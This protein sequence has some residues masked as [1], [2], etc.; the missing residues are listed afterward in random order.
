MVYPIL[1]ALQT[2][3]TVVSRFLGGD[4]EKPLILSFLSTAEYGNAGSV[5]LEFLSV[6]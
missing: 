1:H 5:F 2:S 6:D 4:G 3:L